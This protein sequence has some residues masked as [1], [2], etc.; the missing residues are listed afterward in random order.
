MGR[1]ATQVRIVCDTNVLLAALIFPGGPPDQVVQMV[2]A[3]QKMHFTSPDI[4]TEFRQALRHKF[5][6]AAREAQNAV[7]RIVAFSQ[8]VYPTERVAVVA[9]KAADNR[10]LECAIAARAGVLVTGDLRDLIPLGRY[11]R[12]RIVTAAEFLSDFA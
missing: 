1:Q 5:R 9:R 7:A 3:G 8:M 4:L 10:I 11:R 6:F 2:R 12:T